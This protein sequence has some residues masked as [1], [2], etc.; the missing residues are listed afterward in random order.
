[1]TRTA[2]HILLATLTANAFILGNGGTDVLAQAITGIVIGHGATA[3]TAY[4]GTTPCASGDFI[5]SLDLFGVATCATPAGS[6]NVTAGATLTA[7]RLVIGAGTTAISVLGSAGTTT[8]LL[9]GGSPPTFSAVSLTADVTGTR[10][11]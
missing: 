3:P 9:H 1:M 6:G 10:Q 4:L 8:T 2:L 11:P 5:V 7:N